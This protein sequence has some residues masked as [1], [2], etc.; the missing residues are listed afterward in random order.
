[1][2]RWAMLTALFL[3]GVAAAQ[4]PPS[5]SGALAERNRVCT[6]CHGA[7]GNSAMAGTPSI[8]GQPQVFL[9]NQLVLIREGLRGSAVMQNLLKDLP[10]RDLV[11]LSRYYTALPL[12]AP[13]VVVDSA[14]AQ[15]GR[16]LAGELRCGVC[17]LKDYSGQKQIPRLAGQ[18]EDYLYASMLEFRDSPRPGGD[19]QM[20]AVLYRVPDADLRALAHYLATFR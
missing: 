13:D 6:G 12:R 7:D 10:D 16:T 11:A 1:M 4:T 8:A 20:S 3:S 17:H 19:T 15:R 18:R 2:G 5:L 14:R 9:E